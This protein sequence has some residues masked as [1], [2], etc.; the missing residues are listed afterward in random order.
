MCSTPGPNHCYLIQPFPQ[1][2]LLWTLRPQTQP[3]LHFPI[4]SPGQSGLR[5]YLR[6]WRGPLQPRLPGAREGCI[7]W[8][9]RVLVPS[10]P[11]ERE[12]GPHSPQGL[13]PSAASEQSPTEQDSFP[14]TQE[15]RKGHGVEGLRRTDSER[16]GCGQG[17]PPPGQ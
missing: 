5:Q 6:S 7:H 14:C 12:H 15:L 3:D 11:Q 13:K 16:K 1:L 2:G 10:P 4:P 17:S 9:L 8:R